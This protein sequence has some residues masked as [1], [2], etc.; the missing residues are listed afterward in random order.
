MNKN[1]V[2]KKKNKAFNITL[3]LLTVETFQE[4]FKLCGIKV[5]NQHLLSS[6]GPFARCNVCVFFLLVSQ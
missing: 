6:E 2:K 5:Y 1:K 3:N 4:L